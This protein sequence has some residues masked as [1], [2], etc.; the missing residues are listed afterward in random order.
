M[1]ME[2]LS[3]LLPALSLA[4]GI[5]AFRWPIAGL[6]LYLWFDFMRPHD[7]VVEL[8]TARPMLAIALGLVAASARAMRRQELSGATHWLLP[9]AGLWLALVPGSLSAAGGGPATLISPLKL[10]LVT[11]LIPSILRRRSAFDGAL[12][13][14]AVSLT[15]LALDAVWQGYQKGL[16]LDFDVARVVE[17]P[18]RGG[19]GVFRDNND[20]ARALVFGVAVWS[21]FARGTLARWRSPAAYAGIAVIVAGMVFTGS[22]GGFVTL[23][24]TG[25]FLLFSRL[26]PVPA[27]V[28]SAVLVTGLVGLAMPPTLA[29]RFSAVAHPAASVSVQS[30]VDIWRRGIG[31]AVERP[32][33]GHG[34]GT[35]AV[36]HAEGA[37]HPP[38]TA[39]NIYVELFYEIGLIGLAVYLGWLAS[40]A[41]GLRRL[42]RNSS[43]D[44]WI[45]SRAVALQGG[46]VSF[47]IAGLT[48]G[49]AFQ[50]IP[51]VIVG[52]SFAL[53]KI[54]K[55]AAVRDS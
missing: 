25:L 12:L 2:G 42:A 43:G 14:V 6:M 37:G 41:I 55:A 54:G 32:V 4:A 51:F 31:K 48:L 53:D 45:A 50:S 18:G 8:R 19:D 34:V 44:P 17:G 30:R 22:R 15:V 23:I 7:Y 28:V 39:H 26:K 9:L 1:A 27:A 36:P 38:R 3:P 33:F 11:L 16:H 20:L 49:S 10:G 52:F 21:A 47:L 35:F 46:L 40:A 29:E 13:V 24:G 5:A